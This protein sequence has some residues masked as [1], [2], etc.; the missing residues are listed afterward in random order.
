VAAP[1]APTPRPG[2][3]VWLTGPSGAGKTTVTRALLPRLESAGR[4]VTVLDTVPLLA[5][6]PG[7]RGSRGKLLRKAFVAS[8][9]VR[10]GGI[11]I[12]V[13]VSAT[14]AVRA[15]AREIVGADQFL[16]VHFD[17]PIDVADARRVQRGSRRSI[18][19]RVKRAFGGIAARLPGRSRG[20]YE[21]PIDAEVTI[22]AASCSPD[23]G[24][25]LIFT[26]LRARGLLDP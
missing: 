7:E 25:Q 8:E 5:K 21:P 10:H 6:V 4:T 19:K 18:R 20:G 13:T 26:A 15:E 1:A 24:A 16:E 14:R 12:C 17:L 11:V 3:C 23:E 22:D 2:A 9:V